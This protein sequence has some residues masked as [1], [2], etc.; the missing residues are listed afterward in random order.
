MIKKISPP[1][2]K[3][4]NYKL[5]LKGIITV[6]EFLDG[7]SKHSFR[8]LKAV[9]QTEQLSKNVV[10]FTGKNPYLKNKNKYIKQQKHI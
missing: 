9:V 7:L 5:D 3:T 4:L 6:K 1:H 10:H 2:Y 8:P